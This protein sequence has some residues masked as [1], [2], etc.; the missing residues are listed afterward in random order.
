[1]YYVLLNFM[2][3]QKK[4]LACILKMQFLCMYN[5]FLFAV[6]KAFVGQVT[7]SSFA[8]IVQD[9]S[10]GRFCRGIVRRGP[11][12]VR[13]FWTIVVGVGGASYQD[14]LQTNIYRDKRL[15]KDLAVNRSESRNEYL[16]NMNAQPG[17]TV[18]FWVVNCI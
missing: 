2:F 14:T 18:S 6:M 4:N 8:C 17:T 16:H 10:G 7:A 9:C 11:E 1:M 12:V 3:S 5:V 13:V 15:P